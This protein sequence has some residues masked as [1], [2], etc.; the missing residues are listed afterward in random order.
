MSQPTCRRHQSRYRAPQPG[1]PT[2]S[3]RSIVRLRFRE[4]HRNARTDGGR[5][6]HSKRIPTVV[7]RK[8]SG[9]KRRQRRNRPVHK[10]QKSRLHDLQQEQPFVRG[11]LRRLCALRQVFFFQVA[12]RLRVLAFLIRQ[13]VQQFSR[14][15]VRGACD[16]LLIEA[17]RLHFHHFRLPP[18]HINSQRPHQPRWIPPQKP[19]H[20]FPPDQRNSFA[21][22]RPKHR[23][24]PVSMNHFFLAHALEHIRRSRIRLAQSI[25]EFAVNPSVFFLRRNRQRQNLPLG[26]IPEFLQHQSPPSHT[27]TRSIAQTQPQSHPASSRFCSILSGDQTDLDGG[28]V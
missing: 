4:P 26:Q 3:Q 21:K 10:P 2:A 13:F 24:Q 12:R 27:S 23:Q 18:R 22:T 14:R 25:R 6:P 8:S 28:R 17:L 5:Q 20:I 1:R 11:V 9:K 19:F 15:G 16:G 7:R